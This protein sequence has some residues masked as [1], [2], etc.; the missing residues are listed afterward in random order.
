M[1]AHRGARR[2]RGPGRRFH[3]VLL[4]VPVLVADLVVPRI[5]EATQQA[6]SQARPRDCAPAQGRSSAAATP[7]V[8]QELPSTRKSASTCPRR[9]VLEPGPT[10]ATGNTEV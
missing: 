7:A 8:A 3:G 4:P 6:A 10:A 9:R 5:D 1:L 2:E